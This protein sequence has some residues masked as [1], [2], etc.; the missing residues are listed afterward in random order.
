MVI[1]EIHSYSIYKDR[2]TIFVEF[3]LC[4]ED[5]CDEYELEIPLEELEELCDLFY[6]RE[7]FNDGDDDMEVTTIKNDV[8]ESQL[9]E[10]LITYINQN[11]GV[12]DY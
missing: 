7:W 10:G 11:K 12:L 4:Y 1:E 3:N 5:I 9:S 6:E 8:D 2:G